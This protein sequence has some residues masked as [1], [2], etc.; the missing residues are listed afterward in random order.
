MPTVSLDHCHIDTHYNSTS[1]L[2]VTNPLC[3]KKYVCLFFA[4]M[5]L[6]YYNVCTSLHC[7]QIIFIL[8]RLGPLVSV[9]SVTAPLDLR[10]TYSM[11]KLFL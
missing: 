5:W 7:V 1:L 4:D 10:G 11:S 9:T 8:T 3:H 2:F 6:V